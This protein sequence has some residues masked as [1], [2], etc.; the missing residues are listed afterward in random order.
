MYILRP[1]LKK[2]KVF[3]FLLIITACINR[4]GMDDKNEIKNDTVTKVNDSLITLPKF[5]FSSFID[6]RDNHVYHTIQI[7]NQT[8]CIDNIEYNTKLENCSFHGGRLYSY[9]AAIEACPDSFSIPSDEDWDF[10]F[11]FVEKELIKKSSRYLLNE[12][13]NSHHVSYR[14][15]RGFNKNTFFIYDSLSE[16]DK[17]VIVSIYLNKI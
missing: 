3:I 6:N 4:E 5:K 13:V 9:Y 15:Q 8:W 7:S 10:L 14:F 1:I 16:L 2:F 11:N 17:C 12:I